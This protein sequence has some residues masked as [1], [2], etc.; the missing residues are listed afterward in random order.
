MNM[1]Q[2]FDLI[3][4]ETEVMMENRHARH[5]YISSDDWDDIRILRL[6]DNDSKLAGVGGEGIPEVL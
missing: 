5:S 4:A 2:A 1:T 3:V 6:H